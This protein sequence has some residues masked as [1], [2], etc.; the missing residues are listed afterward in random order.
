MKPRI[1]TE[2]IIPIVILLFFLQA[3]RV[4]FSVMF[5]F[6]YDQVFEGPANAWLVIGNLL[7]IGALLM[8]AW[9]DRSPA[10]QWMSAAAFVSSTARVAL[11]INDP[12]LRYWGALLVI[13]SAGVLMVPLIRLD[14]RRFLRTLI[15]AIVLE[16]L[17][18]IIGHT[19]DVSLEWAAVPILTIWIA[20]LMALSFWFKPWSEPTPRSL[21]GISWGVGAAIGSF[22]FLETSL[23]GL[24]NAI[25][26]WS[27]VS[28]SLTAP[29]LIVITIL[30]LYPGVLSVSRS[31][32]ASKFVRFMVTVMLIGGL[33]LGYFLSG[34]LALAMLL[35][36]QLVLLCVLLMLGELAPPEHKRVGGRLALGLGFFL[37][38]NFLNAFALT[39]PYTLPF[40]RGLGW[41]VYL[42]AGALVA[43][44]LSATQEVKPD[45][46]IDEGA[47]RLAL[48]TILALV[49]VLASIWPAANEA[50][51]DGTRRFASYN[52]HYGYDDDWHTTLPEIAAALKEAR[53][54]VVALQEVDTG[55]MT[56]YST[57][58]A[59]YLARTLGMQVFYLPTVEHLTG[60]ALLYKG[61]ALE[62]DARWLPSLQEQT[63]IIEIV[64][65]WQDDRLHA[66]ATW[67]GLS[68]EDTI[69]QT[70]AAL[71]FI[72][73][74]APA[75]F[76]GDFNAVIEEPEMQAIQAA[77]F[78]DPFTELGQVPAPPT[79]PAVKPQ[80]RIDYIWLRGLE[81]SQAWVSAS[82]ASDH[83]L[84]IV[85]VNQ[86]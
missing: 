5:G 46:T 3:L 15:I 28:Y 76:A 22:L 40:M 19:T 75:S 44:G 2:T 14:I 73:S 78:V 43:W 34:I 4:I 85:E 65:P 70:Q 83:R 50:M 42:T 13:V 35:T 71:E 61:E 23:F 52:I 16:Q 29:A 56:S 53:V 84:V 41:V 58:N 37:A 69:G 55:R 54:D 49:I 9:V 51:P 79:S 18:R 1:L 47:F 66:Y 30:P 77:G 27:G 31:L 6:I 59:Y 80:E 33:L 24:P 64:L 10:W 32:M 38:L 26:R 45:H 67:M 21:N 57:D 82:L 62:R 72:G 17:L 86:P 7:V 74:N 12:W 36:G 81:A 39:Y 11:S 63:G 60:I 8:P 20:A 25:S 48:A 68:D